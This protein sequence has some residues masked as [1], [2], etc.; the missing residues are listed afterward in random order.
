[1]SLAI[2]HAMKKRAAMSKGGRCE[3]H[4]GYECM[5]CHGG[6]MA[7]GGFV[8][9][10]EESGYRSMPREHEKMDEPAMEESD[11]MLNQHGEEEEG[12]M[13]MEEDNE[14]QHE[15]HVEHAEEN[16]DDHEDMIGHIM[17]QRMKHFSKGGRVANE[18]GE[19][20]D[21]EDNQFDDLVKD[22]DLEFHDTAANSGDELDDPQE[23]EDEH[24]M[25]SQIMK[26]RRLKDRLPRIR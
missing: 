3:A 19:H 14:P 23:N 15:R 22:D 8:K 5:M 4:G 18:T 17:K 12:A 24:D 2:A 13:G 26:S 1:M 9:E 21:F 10:E 20:A 16:Q 7:E 25:I 11:R 6:N